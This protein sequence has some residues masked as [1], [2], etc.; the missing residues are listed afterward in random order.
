[1]CRLRPLIFFPRVVA[2]FAARFCS[3]DGLTVD[4]PRARL[5]V[6]PGPEPLRFPEGGVDGRPGAVEGPFI[7]V[8]AD[9]VEIREVDGQHRPLAAGPGEIDN[10]VDNLAQIE[11]ARSAGAPPERRGKESLDN[12]PL[13]IG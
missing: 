8:V 6:T 7:V 5:G 11:R 1:M 12:L 4:T 2:P 9:A 13:V 10:G 3:F